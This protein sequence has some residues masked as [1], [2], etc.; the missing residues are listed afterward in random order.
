MYAPTSSAFD[1]LSKFLEHNTAA[2]ALEDITVELRHYRSALLNF[3]EHPLDGILAR[4]H[5]ASLKSFSIHVYSETM[6]FQKEETIKKFRKTIREVTLP[7]LDAR[8]PKTLFVRG[9][10]GELHRVGRVFSN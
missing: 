8:K 2:N 7:R 9:V 1:R 6:N 4:P 3:E 10:T 5:F